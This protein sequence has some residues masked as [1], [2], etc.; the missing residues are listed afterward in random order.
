LEAV[1]ALAV[2]RV[3]GVALLTLGTASWLALGDA[4][5]RA[6]RALVA[7]MVVYNLGVALILGAVGV[8]SQSTG[9]A[10]WPAVLL[11]AAM[12]VWCIVSLLSGTPAASAG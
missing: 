4:D 3:G 6:A 5:S 9:I 2:A 11:H 10:V 7:A 1:D 8:R 12:T